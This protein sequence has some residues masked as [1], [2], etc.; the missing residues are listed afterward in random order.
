V[1][2]GSAA[3]GEQILAQ[4][5]PQLIPATMELSGCDAVIIRA[6]AD[7]DLA[8]K[9]LTFGLK[10]NGG[11]TCM[12]PKRVFVSAARATELEGRLAEALRS[13]RRKEAQTPLASPSLV[14]SA[15][16]EKERLLLEDALVRGA[17][18]IAGEIAEDGT[19][20]TPIVL[21]GVAS[22][23]KLLQADIFAPVLAIV[24]VVDDH[25]AILRAN[26]CPF[27]LAASI[28]SRDESAARAL[29]ERISAGVVSINDLILPAADARTPFGGRGRS[30]FGV[31]QG[32]EGLLA[33]T[34]P[35]VITVS[36]ARFRPAFDASQPG[37]EQMFRSYLELTHGRGFTLRAHALLTL[38]KN[39]S[40][41]KQSSSL[42][43][44]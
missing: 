14:T 20:V 35:K 39:L 10:L 31:T 19:V 38:L 41:R 42:N 11:A 40:R 17:H 23:S 1:F 30:G 12:S 13:G 15:A 21:G 28:F 6:D 37:D 34:T 16:T 8:V 24:T 29:G 9:A 5:A 4:L 36:R 33:L 22:N 27:A 32:A 7:L 44:K 2:T 25:E 18:L 43:T 26:D 3:T